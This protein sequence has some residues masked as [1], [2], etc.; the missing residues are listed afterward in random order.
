LLLKC[1]NS[2]SYCKDKGNYRRDNIFILQQ[3]LACAR[4]AQGNQA[5][6]K[7]FTERMV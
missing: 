7:R 1:K 2:Q 5:E 4:Q 3:E 6:Y